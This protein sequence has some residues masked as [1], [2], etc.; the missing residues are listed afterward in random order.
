MPSLVYED[1][2]CFLLPLVP[3]LRADIGRAIV[4]VYCAH[5]T[6]EDKADP[7]MAHIGF[8]GLVFQ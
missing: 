3:A 2:P 5:S 4:S 1:L 8:T 7:M 6:F